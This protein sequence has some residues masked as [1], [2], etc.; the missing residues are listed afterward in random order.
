[1]SFFEILFWFSLLSI[2]YAFLG[3]PLVLWAIGRLVS[4]PLARVASDQWPSVSLLISAYNEETALDTKIQN[5]LELDYPRD[6]LE[7]VVVS[8]AS[9]DRTDEIAEMYASQDVQLIRQG[10]RRGK[11]AALNLAVP[12]VSG[13][14]VVFSD[15]N[16]MYAPSALRDLV[17][18]FQDPRI[19]FVTGQTI[20]R[21][22][23]G[24]GTAESTGFYSRLE[25]ITK[26]LESRIGSCVGADGAIF[27][28]RKALFVPLATDDINDFVIPLRIVEAGYRGTL[29]PTAVCYEELADS[30]VGE[31][32][33]QVRV[34]AR[35]LRALF[36]NLSLFNPVRFPLFS[37]MLLSH[38]L[39]KLV[40]PF[41]LLAALVSNSL[42]IR[43]SVIYLSA[44]I[45]QLAFYALA[46]WRHTRVDRSS[47]G[48]LVD[49]SY[50]FS[51]VSFAMLIGWIKFLS[52]ES[53]ST[54]SP[55]RK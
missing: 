46:F 34:T 42:L 40:V 38:K 24:S 50:T 25:L 44:F 23:V 36:R 11:T 6:R 41:F 2:F 14:I 43:S 32:R 15:A 8:D 49:M 12:M 54:W 51:L 53:F 19:G 39:S 37:F 30:S 20:Y 13:E 45:T 55:Q 22:Q 27:A 10:E 47:A 52:G 18:P 7:I 28:I 21:T 29:E 33:R 1:M 26:K 9:T 17:R 3:Y 48:R 31:Y 35:T 5:A 16:S 4:R